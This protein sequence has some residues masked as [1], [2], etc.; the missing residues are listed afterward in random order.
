MRF[1]KDFLTRILID[2]LVANKGRQTIPQKSIWQLRLLAFIAGLF[3]TLSFSPFSFWPAFVVTISVA[4]WLLSKTET[5]KQAFQYGFFLGFGL[6]AS[7][8]SWVYVSVVQYG[9]IGFFLSL[10]ATVLFVSVLAI[11]YGLA[12]L[13]TWWL[14]TKLP[15]WPK[16]LLLA[17]GFLA[18]EYTRSHI[19]TG[20]PWLLTGYSL[21]HTWLFELAPI[22]GIWLLSFLAV[23][24]FATPLSLLMSFAQQQKVKLHYTVLSVLLVSWGASIYLTLFP[25]QWVTQTGNMQ[26]TLIQGNIPQDQKWLPNNAQPI[27]DYYL[28]TSLQHLDSDLIVWPET[29]V[30]YLY[31]DI[32][33]YLNEFNETL[34]TT[35]TTVV[36]GIP[37]L[38][39]EEKGDSFY[40][41]IWALGNGSGLYFKRHL[42]PFGEYIP[43]EAFVGKV[44]DIFGIPLE[45]FQAGTPNQPMLKVGQAKIAAFICYEI[46]YPELVR[47]MVKGS[48]ILLTVSNDGWFGDSLGPWQ[49][50]EIA[51]FRA[52]ESGR[53]LIRSTNTGVTA[54]IDNQGEI[55]KTFPQFTRGAMTADVQLMQGITPYVQYGEL[56]VIAL[57]FLLIIL[58]RV[59]YRR[60]NSK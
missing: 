34:A 44:L 8:V 36:T 22:G 53:Y 32:K 13:L 30:T 60:T 54:I 18:A 33:P 25:A 11:F 12:L 35:N 7:G 23:L 20:F 38:E 10:L 39:R 51:Q 37:V 49:H 50:L 58:Q 19:F 26:A 27:L 2:N 57:V 56:I 15:Q 17:L 21:H 46:A 40:N 4:I 29:A 43:F 6:F 9:Q 24:T 28:N 45:S 42:V 31:S 1:I 14:Q 48:D 3:G 52:K 59:L 47:T 55:I 5:A 16:A 41:A